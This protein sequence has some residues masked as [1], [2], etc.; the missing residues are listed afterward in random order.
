MTETLSRTGPI[1][2]YVQLTNI[3]RE[4]IEA[5]EWQSNE[6]I[7]SENELNRLYGISRMTARQVLAQLVNEGLLFRVQGKGTF[8]APSK[9][10]TR[11]PSYKG[12]REQLEQM[13]YTTSTRLLSEELV[14]ADRHLAERLALPD[15]APVH[16]IRRLRTVDDEPISLHESYIPQRLA[17]DLL[18]HDAAQQQL[19]VILEQH[20]DLVMGRIVETLESG[21]PSP[22]DAKLLGVG[23]N[24]PLLVLR[25]EIS[26]PSGQRFEYSK[27]TFRGDKVRL[28]FEYEI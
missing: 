20:Y 3:L 27:V 8:V 19:C 21:T 26:T 28:T 11:S 22:A 16:K 14:V 6:K 12:I 7:P 25:Q 18:E 9:I 5:G 2:M 1:P 13:G 17:E 4:K 23:R 24:A 10:A 15:G